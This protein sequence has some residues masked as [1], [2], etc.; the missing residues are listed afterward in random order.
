MA[1]R[2]GTLDRDR[3]LDAA[4][5]LADEEGLDALSM[6]RIGRAL[7]VE[8]MSLYNHVADKDDLLDGLVERVLMEIELPEPGREWRD[9]VR[10]RYRSARGAFARHPWAI[11]LLESRS[12]G[13]SPRRLQY[14]DAMLGTFREADFSGPLAMRAFSILDAYLFGFVLQQN[15]LAFQDEDSLQEVG[16]DL[17]RQMGERYPH[18]AAVT[19]DVLASGYDHDAEFEFGLELILDALE[20]RRDGR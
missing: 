14:F 2:S 5:A 19:V 16:A 9:E 10:R 17:L 18:L 7:G 15:S 11:R 12:E 1:K 13:S 20:A 3:V 6:R 8:A 4:L